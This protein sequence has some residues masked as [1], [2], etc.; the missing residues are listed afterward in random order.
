MPRGVELAQRSTD[1]QPHYTP[2]R[3]ALQPI[4]SQ[5]RERCAAEVTVLPGDRVPTAG[6]M[7]TTAVVGWDARLTA[8]LPSFAW[9]SGGRGVFLRIPLSHRAITLHIAPR[10]QAMESP[11]GVRASPHRARTDPRLAELA[12]SLVW[13]DRGETCLELTRCWD[14]A[15]APCCACQRQLVSAP[16]VG[17][18]SGRWQAI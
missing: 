7:Q 12:A 18:R 4:P 15:L 11:T 14:V 5:G 16:E 10:D 6:V 3:P 2:T 13:S 17:S 1:S 9:V 8:T